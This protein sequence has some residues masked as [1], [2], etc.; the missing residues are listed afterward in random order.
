MILLDADMLSSSN[1]NK[2]EYALLQ[3]LPVDEGRAIYLPWG[4]CLKDS[5]HLLEAFDI[6]GIGSI[7]VPI[8]REVKAK[9]HITSYSL[10]VFL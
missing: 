9:F 6:K 2:L 4:Q 1:K 8:S 10:Q 5:R 7:P 3:K